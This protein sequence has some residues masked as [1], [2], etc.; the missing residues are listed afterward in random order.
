M[1]KLPMKQGRETVLNSVI[2]WY[3]EWGGSTGPGHALGKTLLLNYLVRNTSPT[4]FEPAETTPG[5]EV[6]NPI[7]QYSTM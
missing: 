6:T 5:L 1:V 3:K 4:D 2:K 7:T